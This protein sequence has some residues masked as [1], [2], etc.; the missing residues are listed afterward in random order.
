M[1]L[2]TVSKL[3]E[4]VTSGWGI[5]GFNVHN[6]DDVRAVVEGA[7]EV[8]SPVILLVSESAINYGGATYLGKICCTAAQVAKI[9]VA[10]QLDHGHSFELAVECMRYGF[11]G[12]M[13]DGSHLPLRENIIQTK[14]VVEVAKVFGVSVE[15]ELGVLGGKEDDID[16]AD[17]KARLTDPDQA[18]DFVRQTGIDV[19]APAVGTAHGF[20]ASTPNLDFARLQKISSM[21]SVPV[22]LHGSSGLSVNVLR[23]ALASGVA[24]IN[25][26]TDLKLAYVNALKEFTTQNPTEH[27]PRKVFYYARQEMSKLVQ[28]R[29]KLM[30]S[31]GR[32]W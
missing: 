14:K 3:L 18:V 25:V 2:V 9:P 17:D 4:R 10:V 16:V 32:A 5:V 27:E 30:G 23:K 7:E 19:F 22:A 12:V 21:V 31:A 11:S 15:G 24:K 13:F 20:Y 6:L 28:E 8:G 1:P 29:L 26:G